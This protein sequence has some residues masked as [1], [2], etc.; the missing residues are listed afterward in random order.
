M[1][2]SVYADRRVQVAIYLK[3]QQL[4]RLESIP[5]TLKNLLDYLTL[6]CWQK[7]LPV[8]LNQAVADILAITASE[9]TDF[10]TYQAIIQAEKTPLSD[11]IEHL[12]H[13]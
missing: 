13:D 4:Q 11:L 2:Y 7:Q 6:Q 10:L 3:I 5:F 12:V 8:S 1:S 9:L